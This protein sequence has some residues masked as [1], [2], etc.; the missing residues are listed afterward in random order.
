MS[1]LTV[2]QAQALGAGLALS[3]TDL[4][5]IIDREEAELVRRFGAHYSA[6]PLT[7][8]AHGGGHAIY[9]KRQIGAITS[10]VEYLYPGDTAPTTLVAADYYVWGQ[11]GRIERLPYGTTAASCWG[12][13]ITVV[14]T[15]IDDSDLRRMVLIELLRIATEQTTS[16]GGGVAGLGFSVTAGGDATGANWARQREA[17]YARLGWLSR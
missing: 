14:Y 17:Q 8:T 1:L 9:L 5:T 7:E 4:Q 11:E 6:S 10:I 15:P 12:K 3:S 13:V 16:G 2:A